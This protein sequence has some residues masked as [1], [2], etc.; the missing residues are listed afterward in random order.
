MA[1]GDPCHF[2]WQVKEIRW[3]RLSRLS[4][5]PLPARLAG[6]SDSART[7]RRV[8]FCWYSP[9][10]IFLTCHARWQ[11]SYQ[12]TCRVLFVTLCMTVLLTRPE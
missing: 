3:L 5:R 10:R 1:R 6:E 7:T 2:G 4:A 9:V 12:Q 8:A 11:G